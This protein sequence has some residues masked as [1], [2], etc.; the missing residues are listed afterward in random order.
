MVFLVAES[1]CLGFERVEPHLHCECYVHRL[2]SMLS[3]C[4]MICVRV[5]GASALLS[6]GLAC[7]SKDPT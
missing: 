1:W 7:F 5:E 6:K 3:E 4:K 2:V